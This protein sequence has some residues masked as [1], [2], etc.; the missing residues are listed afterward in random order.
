MIIALLL[1]LKCEVDAIYQFT[2]SLFQY[3]YLIA[4]SIVKCNNETKVYMS[5]STKN[6]KEVKKPLDE[7]IDQAKDYGAQPNN[8]KD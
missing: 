5:T 6:K 8:N 1:F 3:V 2:T 7:Q 4:I